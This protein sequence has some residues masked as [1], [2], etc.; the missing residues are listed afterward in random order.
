MLENQGRSFL[1]TE[2]DV[3]KNTVVDDYEQEYRK[4]RA[5]MRHSEIRHRNVGNQRLLGD[6]INHDFSLMV[7]IV[8]EAKI[9][10]LFED[11]GSFLIHSR[12]QG[13]FMPALSGAIDIES[14]NETPN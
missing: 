1:V 5:K 8:G 7:E 13:F 10:N 4:Y 3:E 2:N 12:T 11:S 14:S 9:F 6:T